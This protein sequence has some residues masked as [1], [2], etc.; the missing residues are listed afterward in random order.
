[1]ILVIF[2]DKFSMKAISALAETHSGSPMPG[3]T[4]GVQIQK[5]AIIRFKK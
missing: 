5:L 2:N 1:M 3:L 4:A